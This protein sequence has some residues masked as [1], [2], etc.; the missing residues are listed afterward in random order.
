MGQ[1]KYGIYNDECAGMSPAEVNAH[2]GFDE[3]GYL[4]NG[5]IYIQA[6]GIWLIKSKE[7]EVYADDDMDTENE[8]SP[9][10]ESEEESEE[11]ESEDE[12]SEAKESN[13]EESGD[14]GMSGVVIRE[15]E[16]CMEEVSL[17]CIVDLL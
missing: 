1:L 10:G 2:Y 4:L 11:E 15:E 16:F 9:D 6:L 3:D 5:M 7:D 8:E 17:S 12:E 14:D 13:S